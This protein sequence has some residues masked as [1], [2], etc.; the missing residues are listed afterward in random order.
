M[1]R[2]LFTTML[3]LLMAVAVTAQPLT[4]TSTVNQTTLAVNQQLALTVEFSGQAAQKVG[5]PELPD[6]GGYLSFL[7][8]GGTSQNISFVNGKMS[9]SKSFTYYY[10]A[11][12]EGSFTIPAIKVTHDGKT[13]SSKPISITITKGS[14]QSQQPQQAVPSTQE[15]AEAITK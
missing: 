4:V 1:K 12:K 9:V 10:L 14:A 3:L 11:A 7:S 2:L 15:E 8:S 6:M 5:D 13:Y